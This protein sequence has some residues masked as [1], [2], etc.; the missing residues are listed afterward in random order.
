MTGAVQ[1]HSAAERR[2]PRDLDQASLRPGGGSLAASTA[3]QPVCDSLSGRDPDGAGM[4]WSCSTAVSHGRGQCETSWRSSR[5]SGWARI[6][7]SVARSLILL[8]GSAARTGD[9]KPPIMYQ[10]QPS[11]P[12]GWLGQVESSSLSEYM[13][14]EWFRSF[15]AR[16][17]SGYVPTVGI[18][19]TIGKSLVIRLLGHRRTGHTA[20]TGPT[21]RLNPVDQMV[22]P[23]KRVD[24]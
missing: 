9:L 20:P 12:L 1:E 6:C 4:R 21:V 19:R 16:V 24:R 14:S 13:P 10:C 11:Q 2:G 8:L 17:S 22:C 5:S 3:D 15:R 23:A 18:T 7:V